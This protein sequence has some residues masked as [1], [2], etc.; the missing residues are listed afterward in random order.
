MNDAAPWR[1]YEP[2]PRDRPYT[3][4]RVLYH[5]DKRVADFVRDLVGLSKG[6]GWEH[7]VAL[8]V[9][10]ESGGLLAGVVFHNYRALAGDIEI[11][12]AAWTPRWC[13]PETLRRIVAYPYHELKC[14]R[15]TAR[16]GEH[17]VRAIKFLEG[18]G[19][20]LEGV[21]RKGFDANHNMLIYGVL[22]A[23]LRL[24]MS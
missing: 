9:V 12:A 1:P 8:G 17:N 5:D 22:R 15:C 7:Y 11:T 20:R 2:P 16:T 23:E 6:P 3:I 21:A 13:T 24:R 4:G 19:F 10:N 18:L 14:A